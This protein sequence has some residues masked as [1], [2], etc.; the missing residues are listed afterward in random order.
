MTVNTPYNIINNSAFEEIRRIQAIFNNSPMVE[1]VRQAQRAMECV[2]V[3]TNGMTVMLTEYQKIVEPITQNIQ[4]LNNFYAPILELT[5]HI[6]PLYNNSM[7]SVLNNSIE[8]KNV[9]A[10]MDLSAITNAINSLPNY[11]HLSQI[12]IKDFPFEEV[13]KL[14]ESDN[15]TDDDIAEEISDIVKNKRFSPVETWDNIKK[16]RWFLALRIILCVCMFLASPI[17]DKI[18]D[19]ALEKMGLLQ[20]WQE[21]GIYEYLDELFGLNSENTD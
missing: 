13:V 1:A 20:F 8:A 21:S 14:Y 9:L 3:P 15:I 5:K 16:A 4:Q 17:I 2:Q 10:E 19:N 6:E 12:L 11:E 18:K 7:I